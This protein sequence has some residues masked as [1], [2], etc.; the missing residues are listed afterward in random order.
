MV[1][2]QADA[3]DR[4]ARVLAGAGVVA[5]PTETCYGLAVDP[6]NEQALQRLFLVKNRSFNK[7][8]LLL[9]ND[10]SLLETL[11]VRIPEIYL[12]LIGKYWPGPLTLIFPARQELSPLL[13]GGTG[14][15]GVRISPHPLAQ[16]LIQAFGRAITATSANLSGQP[17]A[18]SAAE[19]RAQ[20]GETLDF[21]LDGGISQES[22]CSTIVSTVDG[23]LHLVRAGAV[24][25]ENHHFRTDTCRFQK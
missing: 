25:L 15:V 4:A 24:N 3:I 7:P 17:P 19:I 18:C 22:R 12:P 16:Q 5:F 14:T 8:V 21:V 6:F 9:I 13:T 10:L 11:V 20:F 2:P 1:L 23:R